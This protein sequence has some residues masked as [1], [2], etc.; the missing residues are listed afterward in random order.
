M[1]RKALLGSLALLAVSASAGVL[2]A[3]VGLRVLARTQPQFGRQMK[4]Y[5][6]LAI[7][8]DAHG[9]LGYRQK[10]NV[11]FRFSN[12]TFAMSNALG[13]RGPE[14]RVPKPAGTFRV[15]LLGESTTHG[16]G[17][18]DAQTIDAYLRHVLGQRHPGR[19]MEVVNLAF[20]GYDAYQIFERLRSDGMRLDPDVI[21]V[22]TGVNDVRNARFANLRDKDP[23]T[24]IWEDDV[25]R[26]REEQRRGGPRLWTRIKHYSYLARM[27]GLLRDR[28]V[29]RTQVRTRREITPQPEAADNFERNLLRIAELARTK[30]IPLLFSTPP[31]VLNE[32]PEAFDSAPRAYLL[33]SPA[34]T[35]QYRDTLAAR[36]RAVVARLAAGGQRV[37]YVPHALPPAMFL[38]DAHLTP[39]GNRQ[40]AIDFASAVA[41]YVT[42][43]PPGAQ[44][45]GRTAATAR[46]PAPAAR[47]R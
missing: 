47:S 1:T 14:I 12:G 40:M 8:V 33:G 4:Q 32:R 2:L 21:I 29:R 45:A 31:S 16:W 38:D 27:P 43:A 42:G 20:D 19:P 25:A 30:D 24:L 26:L 13:F 10:P 6:P 46:T 23:R 37:V 15:V 39:A 34:T 44:A 41:R 28:R 7:L 36:M 17:V 9:E 5:D 22:N 3:E 18:G 35:Q 11:R